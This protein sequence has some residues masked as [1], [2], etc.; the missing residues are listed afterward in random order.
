[1]VIIYTPALGHFMLPQAD[2]YYLRH[3]LP[4]EFATSRLSWRKRGLEVLP[5][6]CDWVWTMLITAAN[7]EY[8]INTIVGHLSSVNDVRLVLG[9]HG[10]R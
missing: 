5:A 4:I 7:C 1:M 3:L 6:S 2:E 8:P 9:S 10:V